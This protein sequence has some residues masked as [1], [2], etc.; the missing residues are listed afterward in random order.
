MYLPLMPA[1]LKSLDLSGY[2]F[3]LSSESGP[4]KGVLKRPGALHVCYCHTPMRYLWDMYEEY[5]KASG[6]VGKIAM[7]LFKNR[8]RKYDLWSAEGV[9]HFIANSN[10]VAERIKRIYGRTA[11]VIYPPVD[12][13]FYSESVRDNAIFGN[14]YYLFVGQLLPYK[15]PDLVLEA[16]RRMNRRVVFVGTGSMQKSLRRVA[17]DNALFVGPASR[18]TLRK[19]YAGARALIFPGIEDFGIVPVEAQAAGTP[20]IALG[21]GGALETVR[22]GETG[23]FFHERNVDAL[24][25]AIE[26]FEGMTF[27]PQKVKS[28]VARFSTEKFREKIR[29]SLS[30]LGV[31]I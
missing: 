10:F 19:M 28:S 30:R 15:G 11:E 8:L 9:D 2:D 22:D 18:D 24:C 6:F 25:N 16:C 26:Q 20:V 3:I 4:A 21:Q 1:A 5:Y 31:N 12:V 23:L 17:P 27:D 14:P 29:F 13:R 7:R